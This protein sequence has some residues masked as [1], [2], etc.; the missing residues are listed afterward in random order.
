MYNRI[1]RPY[2]H[3]DQQDCRHPIGRF[4]RSNTA[5]QIVML[6]LAMLAGTTSMTAVA[7]TPEMPDAYAK[8]PVW[9]YSVN[10]EMGL[11][12]PEENTDASSPKSD[13]GGSNSEGPYGV[14]GI[15]L[16]I[17]YQPQPDAED[18]SLRLGVELGMLADLKDEPIM[19]GGERLNYMALYM[20]A[21]HDPLAVFRRSSSSG[22][23]LVYRAGLAYAR[24]QT[25][26]TDVRA[27][28]PTWGIALTTP[29]TYYGNSGTRLNAIDL[30]FIDIG[31]ETIGLLS[32]HLAVLFSPGWYL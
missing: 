13:K 1:G 21:A 5:L 10:I 32:F 6:C 7:D 24:H 30:T 31:G 28:A 29:T 14:G 25:F 23:R 3:I 18:G 12:Q 2:R 20:T 27:I 22:F 15:K 26:T 11:K 19:P 16:G 17:G 9:T 8:G 4:I